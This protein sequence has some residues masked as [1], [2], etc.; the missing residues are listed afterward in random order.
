MY[1][2]IKSIVVINDDP[3]FSSYPIGKK[4]LVVGHQIFGAL[5]RV[6]DSLALDDPDEF[7]SL[8]E[9]VTSLY[10]DYFVPIDLPINNI[11]EGW[12]ESLGRGYLRDILM[13]AGE[14]L[15]E[16]QQ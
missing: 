9:A 7:E 3:N 1:E 6:Y 8:V 12:A 15:K 11:A 14:R 4:G 10:D 16:R 13:A 5:L 2:Q